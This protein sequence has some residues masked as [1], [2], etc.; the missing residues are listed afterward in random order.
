[1]RGL[2]NGVALSL[3]LWAILLCIL[4]LLLRLF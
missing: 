1:M 3:P 2:L 4:Q